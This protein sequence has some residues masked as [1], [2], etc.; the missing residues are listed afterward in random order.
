[1]EQRMSMYNMD[2]S[3]KIAK[4]TE[5]D[6]QIYHILH[7]ES[8]AVDV[9]FTLYNDVLKRFQILKNNLH[10]SSSDVGT[11]TMDTSQVQTDEK[12]FQDAT[13]QTTNGQQL[14][15]IAEEEEEEDEE[16]E[17]HI[18]NRTVMDKFTKKQKQ[19]AGK[20]LKELNKSDEISFNTDGT[21]NYRGKKIKNSDI[22]NIIKTIVTFRGKA[23][24]ST[25]G[26]GHVV[27]ALSGQRKLILNT[28]VAKAWPTNKGRK[29]RRLSM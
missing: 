16:K 8:L 20:I 5:L 10:Y 12:H 28:N 25:P 7:N 24:V 17:F 3:A 4:L 23:D 14:E 6:K 27:Y 22:N 26:L 2:N 11:Q 21:I 1:M 19:Y 29:R 18:I 13:T 15:P 9:K